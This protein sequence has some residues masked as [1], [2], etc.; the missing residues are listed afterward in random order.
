MATRSVVGTID[1]H[2]NFR[3]RYVHYDG[4]PHTRGPALSNA[5]AMFDGGL[6]QLLIELTEKNCG[7]YSISPGNSVLGEPCEDFPDEWR[8]GRVGHCGYGDVE[9]W[10]YFFTSRDPGTAELVIVTGLYPYPPKEVGRIKVTDLYKIDEAA[11]LKIECGERFERCCHVAQF[12]VDEQDL[13]QESTRL[14]MSKWLGHER[15]EPRD[16]VAALY[17]GVRYRLTGSGF[18]GGATASWGGRKGWWYAT[19]RDE[20]GGEA[21]VPILTKSGNVPASTTLIYPPIR[22]QAV[23]A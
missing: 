14:S 21:D 22:G 3:G 18:L 15:L 11:W 1:E 6:D 20:H 9:V 12:H 5:L 23:A 7:W 19:G 10:G 13:P 16:A 17:Q 4:D 2:G 8:I